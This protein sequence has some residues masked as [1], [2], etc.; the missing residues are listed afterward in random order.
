MALA[1]SWVTPAASNLRRRATASQRRSTS[2]DPSRWAPSPPT[3]PAP[4]PA[5]ERE[6]AFGLAAPS[7]AVPEV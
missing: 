5:Q 4:S 2:R 7:S 1:L 3:S 6:L